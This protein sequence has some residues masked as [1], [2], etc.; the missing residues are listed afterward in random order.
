[1]SPKKS[2]ASVLDAAPKAAGL[3]GL[4]R[5]NARWIVAVAVIG[6]GCVA[7][8]LLLW[9]QVRD[10]VAAA[11]DYRLDPATIEI[12]PAVP[13]WIHADL[14]SE[15]IRDASLDTG[16]STLDPELTMRIAQAFRLHPWVAKVV[17]VS[18]H[19]PAAVKVELVYRRP[20]AMVEVPGPALLPVDAEGVVL[21]TDDSRRS[22]RGSIPASRKS[23]PR[24]SGR[25][26]RAGATR[27]SRAPPRWPR[28]WANIGT[29]SACTTSCL[30]VARPRPPARARP[31]PTKSSPLRARGSIGR[32]PGAESGEANAT[33]KIAALL[34]YAEKHRG[35]LDD[36][37]KPQRLDV[38]PVN[39]MIVAP[40]P[41]IQSLPRQ[42][43]DAPPAE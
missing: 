23:R 13:E 35:S 11:P 24:P 29:A 15:V 12:S 34:E 43:N 41:A 26:A 20:A 31:T 32:P 21:P 37:G 30:R 36:G 7:G 28:C 16:L 25:S 22:M 5:A 39:G 40:R 17:R 18:K 9:D 1:M 33:S 27:A 6:G 42:L 2:E 19:F 8:W 38:R 10:H 14:K 3:A 4:L